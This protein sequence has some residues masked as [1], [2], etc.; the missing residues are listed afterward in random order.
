MLSVDGK[1]GVKSV[2]EWAQQ[3]Y[4]QASGPI[5]VH[6]LDQSTSGILVLAKDKDTHKDL[7]E[8]F[9]ARSVEKQ[10]IAV[11]DGTISTTSGTISLPL[12]LDYENRPRQMVAADGRS[13]VTRYEV[14][15]TKNGLT[16]IA[17]YPLTGRTHQLRVHAAHQDGLNSPIVG[18]DIYG[19]GG[20]RL[21]LHA[22]RLTFTHP[23][24]SQ[25]ITIE[26]PPEF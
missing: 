12:K 22:S 18:D 11:L 24:T 7:Q 5:I 16:R 10:Y 9:I 20:S 2:E 14:L 3:R 25:R 13:A 26:C 19:Y 17:F 23:A 6:R 15:G 8:Q 1:S 4:P 21:H